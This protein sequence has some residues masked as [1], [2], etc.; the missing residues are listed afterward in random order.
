MRII[1]GAGGSGGH[2]V[3]AIAIAQKMRQDGALVRFIGNKGSMEE[4]LCKEAGFELLYIN[5]QK[6]Y[7]KITFAHFKFPF[8]LVYSVIKAM[9]Y[10]RDF[11]AS[12]VFCTGGFVSGPVAIAAVLLKKPLF[13]H[14]S[15]SYPGLTTRL[16]SRY[17]EK[18]F[19]AFE[20]TANYL[21]KGKTLTVGIPV[22]RDI[23]QK[24]TFS[25]ESFGFQPQTPKL[26]IVGG[27]Q[28]SV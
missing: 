23:F 6:L 13:F 22:K 9:Q 27:S 5:V 19:T 7:R 3:P 1:F 21:S 24:T 26:L 25:P 15:N 14:E 18:V 2:I 17:T 12:A 4:R 28:G 10:T 20:S 11:S 16:L 8:L